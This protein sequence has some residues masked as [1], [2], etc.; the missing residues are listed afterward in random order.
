MV[1]SARLRLP[2]TSKAWSLSGCASSNL[3]PRIKMKNN[4]LLELIGKLREKSNTE[5]SNLWKSIALELEKSSRKRRIVNLFKI[6]KYS[7]EDDIV[8]VPGK[9]LAT[10]ELTHKITVA[11]YSFSG[12]AVDK[13]KKING[14][15][16]SIEK[17][18]EMKPKNVK[19][20][21]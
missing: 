13:I 20:I 15:A 12:T 14:N 4:K 18:M 7:K 5:K 9:V 19:I 6:D 2:E 17:L 10:G 1:K 16:V 21:G 11:A 8:I 3:V